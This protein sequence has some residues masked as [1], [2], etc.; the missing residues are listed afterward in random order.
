MTLDQVR[1]LLDT[2][3]RLEP[4]Q[5][6]RR[7]RLMVR[8]RI[9]RM[10]RSRFRL[11]AGVR[12][13]SFVPL[14]RGLAEAALVGEK[15]AE[16][17]RLIGSG[18][19][20]FLNTEICYPAGPDWHDRAASQ[21][22][23]YQLHYFHYVR[24]LAILA[25]R[26]ERRQAYETFRSL[27]DSWVTAN[28]Y[29]VGDGWHPYT[30]SLRIVNW[31]HAL[32]AFA[33]ELAVDPDFQD[34][35]TRAIYGQARFVARN[36]E[37]DVRGN[38]LL[39][40]LRA[41]VWAGVAFEGEEA[42]GWFRTGMAMLE[43]EVAEQVLAD[44]GHF[45]RVPGYHVLVLC[46]LLETAEFLRRN[47]NVP[48]WLEAACERMLDF[49]DALLPADGRLPLFKDTTLDTD[50]HPLDL[51]TGSGL[52]SA[53][54]FAETRPLGKRR[55]RPAS[56]HLES[57]G[58]VVTRSERHHLVMDVGKPCPEYLPAHAH[59]D[60]FSFELTIGGMP[61]VVD[62]G[63]FEYAPGKWRDHFRSTRAHNTV[64]VA[65]ANQS[66]VWGSFRVA[67]RA[68]PHNVSFVRVGDGA[69]VQA[70]HDGY[71]RLTPAVIH[72]RTLASIGDSLWIV[73]DELFG[74]GASHAVN[75]I[76]LLNDM[77]LSV[78]GSSISNGSG[79]YSPRF[80]EVMRNRVIALPL[81]GVLPLRMAYTLSV[82]PVASLQMKNEEVTVMKDGAGISLVIPRHAR[83]FFRRIEG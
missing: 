29:L 36:L 66:E 57:S 48:E 62:S 23:R 15:S 80:G 81:D 65:G 59:A 31:C 46:D 25:A 24:E 72:R 7:I 71:A 69:I 13:A 41:L 16:A 43:T 73:V 52:Y 11:P 83:P 4:A 64:E 20:T 54:I 10:L 6:R 50:P 68:S 1:L 45:E 9:W 44:G 8:R 58:Y 18:Q 67:R 79:Y 63:V 3:R 2:A 74:N 49:L 60:M 37:T 21:L 26:G 39:K 5:L 30:V 75:F 27:A 32:H 22:W 12:R 77:A 56:E 28:R 40:N 47:R 82:G 34:R 76:H 55:V 70:E 53:L 42:A 33:H 78:A 35:L 51:F 61:V 17:A 38:H 14:W 19:F